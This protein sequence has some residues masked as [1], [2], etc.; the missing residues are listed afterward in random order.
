MSQSVL[1]CLFHIDVDCRF[2]CCVGEEEDVFDVN[3]LHLQDD[4]STIVRQ[5]GSTGEEQR[6]AGMSIQGC[7]CC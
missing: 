3:S 2:I 7:A 5:S 4:S 6:M 1:L